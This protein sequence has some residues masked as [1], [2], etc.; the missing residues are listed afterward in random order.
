MTSGPWRGSGPDAEGSHRYTPV[1][2]LHPG[3]AEDSEGLS[4]AVESY[5]AR[6]GI[7]LIERMGAACAVWFRRSGRLV[8]ARQTGAIAGQLSVDDLIEAD[9]SEVF[10]DVRRLGSP[11]EVPARLPDGSSWRARFVPLP[12]GSIAAVWLEGPPSVPPT[13]DAPTTAAT[14]EFDPVTPRRLMSI[15]SH[16][17]NLADGS[18]KLKERA[19][20]LQRALHR[21]AWRLLGERGTGL[22]VDPRAVHLTAKLEAARPRV[23]AIVPS[24]IEADW[25][26]PPGL[27]SVDVP[28]PAVRFIVEELV[29][30]SVAAI[31]EGDGRIRIRGGVLDLDQP[32]QWH[33]VTMGPGSYLFIE[34]TDTG[35]GIDDRLLDDLIDGTIPGSLRA[36]RGLATGW[37]GGLRLRT[38]V[39]RGTIIQVAL[40]ALGAQ[41]REAP[42]VPLIPARR[43]A[44]VVM[45]AGQVRDRIADGLREDG[46][47]VMVTS[48]SAQALTRFKERASRGGTALLVVA[49]D[50]PGG[51][52][53]DLAR[54]L[55]EMAPVLPVVLTTEEPVEEVEEDLP[56]LAPGRVVPHQ[57]AARMAVGAAKALLPRVRTRI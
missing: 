15:A 14:H 3:A 55:R 52:G 33:D 46:L 20:A 35:G 9:L 18:G 7:E 53:F 23:S 42:T 25:D 26:I 32:T 45:G 28:A 34:V 37:G 16:V 6:H 56:D 10:S 47:E 5:G 19:A 50:L 13:A 40:P 29:R 24:R 22:P 44:L 30:N 49:H 12:E 31:G 51:L 38:A 17:G 4:L 41:E 21:E 1:T 11:V 27:A 57:Y 43:C 2:R 39:G 8:L 54:R 48:D 36:V